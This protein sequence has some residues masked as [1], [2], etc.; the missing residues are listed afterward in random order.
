[1]CARIRIAIALRNR[2][3]DGIMLGAGLADA[4]FLAQLRAAEGAETRTDLLHL[5]RHERVAL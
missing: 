4:I 5:R 3:H 2:L 1:M